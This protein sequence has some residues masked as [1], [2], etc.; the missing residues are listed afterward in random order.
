MSHAVPDTQCSMHGA[1]SDFWFDARGLSSD[2]R[3]LRQA[4]KNGAAFIV[5]RAELRGAGTVLR[6]V[7]DDVSLVQ[8]MWSWISACMKAHPDWN[9]VHRDAIIAGGMTAV[10]LIRAD[11]PSNFVEEFTP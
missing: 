10:V 5:T 4:F 11:A 2:K 7:Q 1:W 3:G 6:F 8:E 9:E